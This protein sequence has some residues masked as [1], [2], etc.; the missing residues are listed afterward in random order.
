MLTGFDIH[1]RLGESLAN[2]AAFLLSTQVNFWL[3]RTTTWRD[4]RIDGMSAVGCLKQ[5]L[6]FNAMAIGS[7]GVNQIVFLLTSRH[8]GAVPASGFGTVVASGMTLVMSS[9]AVFPGASRS[10][11]RA[12]DASS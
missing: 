4:R 10:R 12:L 9:V 7:L 3:S 2:A 6:A 11:R 8:I 1:S 5:Q